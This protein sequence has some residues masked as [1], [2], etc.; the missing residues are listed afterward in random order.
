MK[1]KDT[2]FIKKNCIFAPKFIG[3]NKIE[4]SNEK[5]ISTLE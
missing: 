3:V 5:D 1:K 2:T 4:L